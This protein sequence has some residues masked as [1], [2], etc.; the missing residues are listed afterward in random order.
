MRRIVWCGALCVWILFGVAAPVVARAAADAPQPQKDPLCWS[1]ETCTQQYKNASWCNDTDNPCASVVNWINDDS[2]K[3]RCGEWGFCVPPGKAQLA[4]AFNGTNKVTDV[5]QYILLIYK[6]L[7]GIAG[8]IA[9]ALIVKGGFEYMIAGGSSE[10]M[11][12]AKNTVGAAV[13]GLLL[14]LASFT[15][16]NTLNPDL[17]HLRLP[18]VYMV[19]HIALGAD[20]CKDVSVTTDSGGAKKQF[21]SSDGADYTK[22][23]WNTAQESTVCGKQYFIPDGEGKTCKGQMCP[24]GN[25]CY[26]YPVTNASQCTEGILAGSILSGDVPFPYIDNNV[27][28][29]AVCQGD[30]TE[31]VLDTVDAETSDKVKRESYSF[32]LTPDEITSKVSGCTNGVKG[33]FLA[34]EVNDK[35][36]AKAGCDDWF[37]IGRG[38]GVCNINL[39]KAFL[40]SNPTNMV[41]WSCANL[42]HSA[43]GAP[44]YNAAKIPDANLIPMSE[45]LKGTV[46]DISLGRSEFPSLDNGTTIYGTNIPLPVCDTPDPTRCLRYQ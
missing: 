44:P 4:I 26:T 6:F 10:R 1:Q 31:I 24:K 35:G 36:L 38:G 28:L 22:A 25:V 15:L 12:S 42:S 3:T 17:V 20:W 9:A 8:V 40:G 11:T 33:F 46:C 19:R 2:A 43:S 29:I 23:T 41:G 27:K 5:G 32:K 39:N 13:F 18:N 37:A 45:L 16:L 30:G 14:V 21:A 7:V 34:G